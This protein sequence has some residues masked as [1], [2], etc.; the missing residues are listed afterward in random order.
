MRRVF[1]APRWW[2]TTRRLKTCVDRRP[3]RLLDA[4]TL[5]KLGL[6]VLRQALGGRYLASHHANA[7]APKIAKH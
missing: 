3:C 4:L 1:S 7:A 2:A 6:P 5:L